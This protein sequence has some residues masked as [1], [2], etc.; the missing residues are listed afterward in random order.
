MHD[1]RYPLSAVV[2]QDK[3]KRALILTLIYPALGGVL[4]RGEKGTA[5]STAVRSLAALM[6]PV[7]VIEGCP[8]G[9]RR[10][11]PEF[12]CDSCRA[13][14]TPHFV[15]RPF[16]VVD[17][18]VSAT[19]DR[20]VG[21]LDIERILKEG[22]KAFE[23]GL[24]AEANGNILYIDEVN[25]LEDHL[26]DLLLDAAA[27]G[28]NIIERDGISYEHPARFVLVGT[29]NPE[30]GELRPQLLDRFG[31]VV[32]VEA[33]DDVDERVTIMERRLAFEADP[34]AFTARWAEEERALG[35]RIVAAQ[36]RFESVRYTRSDL[37][38]IARLSADL[39][40][41]GH[42]GELSM[43]KA[44]LANAAFEGRDSLQTEDL[45]LAA[46][47][48]LPHRL[49]RLPF[50]QAELDPDILANHLRQVLHD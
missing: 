21:T 33:S 40:L 46:E 42:R 7:D 36:Q 38:A 31:L 44:A 45:E 4:I 25:L 30:E 50:E 35:E 27:M 18:P 17:L 11:T 12:W 10:D 29:M 41:D 23:P 13:L 22:D 49:R 16:R 37:E 6:P 47:L 32:D 2:G 26:V 3:M 48:A 24:L 5:K 39:E 28:R 34:A 19:E 15:R 8:F 20:V 9:C 43:L 14:E 1:D